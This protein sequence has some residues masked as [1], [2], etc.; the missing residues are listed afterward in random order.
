MDNSDTPLSAKT[1]MLFAV[2]VMMS[3]LLAILLKSVFL[4]SLAQG[5]PVSWGE[6]VR[7]VAM[8]IATAFIWIWFARSYR[9]PGKK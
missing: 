9:E 8:G 1:Q 6:W 2:C 4:D 3:G 5:Y 7:V